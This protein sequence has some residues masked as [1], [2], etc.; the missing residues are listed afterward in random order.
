MEKKTLAQQRKKAI[1]EK[2]TIESQKANSRTMQEEKEKNPAA[3]ALGKL[4]VSKLS[5]EEWSEHC[6]QAIK[7]RWAKV[8]QGNS[9]KKK[10]KQI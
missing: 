6:R 4:R 8:R 3:V 7:K 10:R 5:K 1:S 9:S 2:A